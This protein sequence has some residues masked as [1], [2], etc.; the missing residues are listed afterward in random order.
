LPSSNRRQIVDFA[1]LPALPTVSIGIL[2]YQR[3][4]SL[5]ET[6]ASL[7]P[8]ARQ[9]EARRW[10]LHDVLIIDNDRNA[11]AR[12][13]V[14]E[15]AAVGPLPLRYRHEPTP[16]LAAARNR[17]LDEAVGADVLVFIDDDEV[18]E[19]GWPDGLLEVMA[20]TGAA[21]VGGPVRT[22]FRNQPPT[23]VIDGGL[24]D[25][26]E[27]VDR[28]SQTWLRSGNLALDLAQIRTHQ[29]RFDQSF[30]FTGGE[31]TDFSLRAAE[32]GLGL[33]WSAAAIVTELV[34]PDRTT[35]AWLT[36][37]E[38]RATTNWVRAELA[39]RGTGPRRVLIAGRGL[40]RLGQGAALVLAG[41]LTGSRRRA[42]W[43]VMRMARGVGSLHGLIGRAK[44]SYGD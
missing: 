42:A 19:Q 20:A 3:P 18:A 36:R 43:G 14:D 9:D 33:R 12:P 37:R 24:F 40:I 26:P 17:A 44:A 8:L 25:R 28:S 6:L 15:L 11:S 4:D 7:A 5:R 34:G 29:L 27:P 30:A 23:W 31:D 32:L 16:G 41:G 35:L 38:R 21:L 1:G 39:L 10:R 2:T 13:L 22:R